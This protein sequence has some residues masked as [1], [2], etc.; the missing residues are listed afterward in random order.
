M[1]LTYIA[2]R[3]VHVL[4]YLSVFSNICTQIFYKFNKL[5]P[6]ESLES[7]FDL[8]I[9][10]VKVNQRSPLK[11]FCQKSLNFSMKSYILQF[12]Y[13]WSCHKISQG[14]PKVIRWTLNYLGVSSVLNT[15][16]Q[17]SSQLVH[18][19]QRRRLLKVFTTNRHGGHIG[20]VT[21]TVFSQSKEA[22]MKFCYKWHSGF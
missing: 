17:I 5:F 12:S 6:Y 14:Q 8:A 4:V 22:H 16:Y 1:I 7:K 15:T 3:N 13:V 9:K 20:H 10:N 11:L 19:F 2:K 18:W 21:W